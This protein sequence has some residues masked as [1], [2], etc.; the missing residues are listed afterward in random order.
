MP[1]VINKG[2]TNDEVKSPTA[3]PSV[4][5]KISLVRISEQEELTKA[6]IPNFLHPSI[7]S[8]FPPQ[9]EVMNTT[10]AFHS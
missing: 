7:N 1:P 10:S 8:L 3:C 5:R 9:F 6:G 2:K 4:V